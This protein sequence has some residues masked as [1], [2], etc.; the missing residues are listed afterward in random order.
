MSCP[1]CTSIEIY[2][3]KNHAS[4]KRVADWIG[5]PIRLPAAQA[6]TAGPEREIAYAFELAVLKM[7]RVVRAAKELI[8]PPPKQFSPFSKKSTLQKAL[9]DGGYIS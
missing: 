1:E 2:C 9:V 4:A 5:N 6:F 8:E 7:A 3:V